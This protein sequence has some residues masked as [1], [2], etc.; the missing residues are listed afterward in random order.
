MTIFCSFND[1]FRYLYYNHMNLAVKTSVKRRP[2]VSPDALEAILQMHS[3]FASSRSG[4]REVYLRTKKDNWVVGK[5]SGRREF[6]IV[7]DQKSY[8]LFE[9]SDQVAFVS[10][11][12][13]GG[14]GRRGSR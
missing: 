13:F 1:V 7:F 8:S 9:V 4:L 11:L 6:Y 12:L 5:Y 3:S 2:N 14:E 10:S